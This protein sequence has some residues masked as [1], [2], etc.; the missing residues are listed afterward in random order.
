MA[1]QFRLVKSY[2][3]PTYTQILVYVLIS[4]NQALNH[5]HS[6]GTETTQQT[7]GVNVQTH[8]E[9]SLKNI[10][11]VSCLE[12]HRVHS[13]STPIINFIQFPRLS[14]ISP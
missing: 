10:S 14:T 7:F 4:P 8:V 12:R 9:N 3:L 5:R 11:Y 13:I 1:Q 6:I 2:N